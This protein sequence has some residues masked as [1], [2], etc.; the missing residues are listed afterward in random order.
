MLPMA[1]KRIVPNV[2][3]QRVEDVASS[4]IASLPP[5]RSALRRP[6]NPP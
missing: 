4:W 2:A 1:V 3:A 5:S 6:S